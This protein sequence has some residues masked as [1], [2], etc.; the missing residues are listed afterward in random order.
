AFILLFSLPRLRAAKMQLFSFPVKYYFTCFSV[1]FN[2]RKSFKKQRLFP[3]RSQ[4]YTDF[5]ILQKEFCI[6]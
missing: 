5:G 3:K 4:M 2:L 6:S 1:Y